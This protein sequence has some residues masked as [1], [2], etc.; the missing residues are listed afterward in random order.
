MITRQEFLRYL[1]GLMRLIRK[2]LPSEATE[3][4]FMEITM[5]EVRHVYTQEVIAEAKDE[6][7][8]G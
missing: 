8:D 7:V 5:S 6:K 3:L 1:I 4:E 2:K